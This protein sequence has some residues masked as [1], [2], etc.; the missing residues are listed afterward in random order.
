MR[1]ILIPPS[2]VGKTFDKGWNAFSNIN[3][4][5][6]RCARSKLHINRIH[7]WEKTGCVEW[8]GGVRRAREKKFYRQCS[9]VTVKR[10][11]RCSPVIEPLSPLYPCLINEIRW[12]IKFWGHVVTRVKARETFNARRNEISF[13]ATNMLGPKTPCLIFVW[14]YTMVVNWN[15]AIIRPL[16]II[17]GRK[18]NGQAFSFHI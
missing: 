1:I 4:V 11:T 15:I 18:T 5:S 2:I 3:P 7:Y 8:W 12:Q 17:N 14:K 6:E 16:S 9:S 13:R 10:L